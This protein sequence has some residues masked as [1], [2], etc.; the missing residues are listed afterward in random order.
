MAFAVLNDKL[1]IMGGETKMAPC[2][3]STP[4][5]EVEYYDPVKDKWSDISPIAIERFRFSG[6]GYD[7]SIYDFG[8]QGKLTGDHYP[9]LSDVY[10]L[11]VTSILT[12]SL[13]T[14][15]PLNLMILLL[16]FLPLLF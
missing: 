15:I 3:N 13:G 2:G 9:V 1:F 11:D 12:A 14:S 5:A 7:G 8:G 4:T 10:A 6:T 16:S